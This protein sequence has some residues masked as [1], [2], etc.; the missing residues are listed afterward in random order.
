MVL[1]EDLFL[2]STTHAHT[3]KRETEREV[4]RV[5]EREEEDRK[6]KRERE[7]RKIDVVGSREQKKKGR[8]VART[9]HQIKPDRR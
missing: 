6:K 1:V 4:Y 3:H 9:Q 8:T 5:R 7:E 2:R